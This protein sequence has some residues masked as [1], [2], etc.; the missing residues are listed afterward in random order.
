MGK[1]LYDKLGFE[2]VGA[3]RVKVEGEEVVLDIPAMVHDS[4]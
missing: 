3:V 4:K 1:I 2:Q